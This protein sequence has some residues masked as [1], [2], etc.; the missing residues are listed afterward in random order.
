MEYEKV[1]V[2]GVSLADIE[3]ILRREGFQDTLLQVQKPGQ[4]FGLVKRLNPPWEMHVRGFEDGHLEAEIEISRDYLEH[5]NDSY[6]RSAAT[7]LSQL[8]SKYG[9]PHTVKRDSN[10]KLDLE[11]P[12]TLTPW[13]PI[14]AALGVI[15]LTSYILRKKE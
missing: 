1:Q 11:V 15:I 6:R 2:Y 5:L 9:I 7:E 14:V 8:L 4:V 12:E 3:Q 10:V 13:K